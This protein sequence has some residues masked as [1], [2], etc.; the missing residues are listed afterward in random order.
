MPWQYSLGGEKVSLGFPESFPNRRMGGS[1]LPADGNY[2][3]STLLTVSELYISFRSLCSEYHRRLLMT[4]QWNRQDVSRWP[5]EGPLQSI[6]EVRAALCHLRILVVRI[7]LFLT[8]CL[9]LHSERSR[10][11]ILP[12]FCLGVSPMTMAELWQL[13]HGSLVISSWHL[14]CFTI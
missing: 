8:V 14:E 9:F 1:A 11:E 6:S 10:M 3:K 4:G 5:T 13:G 12:L 2:R 7:W